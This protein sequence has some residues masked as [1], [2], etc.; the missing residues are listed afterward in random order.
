MNGKAVMV[1]LAVAGIGAAA[2]FTLKKRKSRPQGRATADTAPKPKAAKAQSWLS[3]LRP[4]VSTPASAVPANVTDYNNRYVAWL[5]TLP[6]DTRVLAPPLLPNYALA[7]KGQ[8]Q[9]DAYLKGH[10]AQ[11]QA[12][13]DGLKTSG[14]PQAATTT[15]PTNAAAARD[16]FA[17]LDRIVNAEMSRPVFTSAE[18]GSSAMYTRLAIDNYGTWMRTQVPTFASLLARG[19]STMPPSMPGLDPA[20]PIAAAS[21]RS[22]YDQARRWFNSLPTWAI[23][24]SSRI[25]GPVP[26]LPT[27][28]PG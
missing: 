8:P 23:S 3:Q 25:V 15:A 11:V 14:S 28:M 24:G 27:G 20:S 18:T 19:I 13:W 4:L 16:A 22:V 21:V 10:A 6:S 12:W 17:D 7:G 9:I 5:N 26:Q 1:L 2:Y